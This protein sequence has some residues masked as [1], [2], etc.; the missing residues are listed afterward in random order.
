MGLDLGSWWDALERSLDDDHQ[1]HAGKQPRLAL[2]RSNDGHG[3]RATL[4]KHVGK[5]LVRRAKS[6]TYPARG[7]A[8]RSGSALGTAR[9]SAR[10]RSTRPN[11][12]RRCDAQSQLRTLGSFH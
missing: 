11:W 8:A 12:E 4:G 2:A 1:D 9:P 6:L 10:D 7:V 5:G 3:Q